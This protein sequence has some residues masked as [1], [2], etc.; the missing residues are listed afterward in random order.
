MADRRSGADRRAQPRLT[1]DRRRAGRRPL[2][3]GQMTTTLSVKV[4]TDLYDA[5][6]AAAR[7]ERA[8]HGNMS[9]VVR[10]AIVAFLAPDPPD[11]VTPK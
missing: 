6:F 3:P 8:Y 4:P 1:P 7:A 5:V 9:E 10:S 2:T 11:F